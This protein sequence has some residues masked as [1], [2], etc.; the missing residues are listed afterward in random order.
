MK[1]AMYYRQHEGYV[2]CVLCPHYCKLADGETGRCM[3][4]KNM[5]GKLYSLNYGKVTSY[6]FDPIEKKPLFHFH[7]GST[8]FS[9]G[10][11]GCNFRCD[12][13]QN[14]QIVEDTSLYVEM[15]NS[16]I[17]DLSALNGSVGIAYTYNEPSIF[18]EM[19]LDLSREVHKM[20]RKNIMVT[21]G[22]LNREPMEALLP[23]IDAMNI[24][25]KS[26]SKNY[27]ATL[28]KGSLQPVLDTIRLAAERTHVEVTTLVIDGE[29]S[30]DEEMESL[31]SFLGEIDRNIP[32][33]LSRFFPHNRMDNPPTRIETLERLRNIAQRHLNYVYIGNVWGINNDTICP[34]CKNI[35]IRR[36]PETKVVGIE[37]G[38]CSNCGEK[39]SVVL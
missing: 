6:G 28:C 17:L 31:A 12:F 13:C 30:T 16:Q 38:R 11:F 39:V 37:K 9:F 36:Y 24:D 10:T 2:Y 20:G 29:N 14:W 5:D 25:L 7:P 1:E 26:M 22:F 21:N 3:A 27:Y 19:V 35:L 34:N 15:E 8:V 32:L 18:Y 4:R 23:Y 33:H